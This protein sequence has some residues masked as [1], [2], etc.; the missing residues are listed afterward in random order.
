MPYEMKWYIP[1]Q[2]LYTRYW[3]EMNLE[4]FRQSM[5]EMLDY[6]NQCPDDF[7]ALT[8]IRD[9]TVPLKYREVII[10]ARDI[11]AKRIRGWEIIV[12]ELE[13]SLVIY[14]IKIVRTILGVKSKNFN[15][16]TEALQFLKEKELNLEWDQVLFK[17]D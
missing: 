13:N 4:D 12:G 7:H 6:V 14:S 5:G 10:G 8:D 3:G 15:T 1:S 2:V 11:G 9:V 17:M 16:I